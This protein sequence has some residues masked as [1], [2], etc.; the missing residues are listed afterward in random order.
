MDE[1]SSAEE[2]LLK[3]SVDN[4]VKEIISEMSIADQQAILASVGEYSRPD[5]N[6]ATY[7][8]RLQR[9]MDKLRIQWGERYGK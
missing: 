6:P 4:A 2:Q 7:R 1:G 3:L 9:A 5:V 8:K